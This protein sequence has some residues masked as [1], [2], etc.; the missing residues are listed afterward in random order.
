MTGNQSD[1]CY[2]ILSIFFIS[3]GNK[4]VMNVDDKFVYTSWKVQTLQTRIVL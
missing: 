3:T 2:Y 4:K 1:I